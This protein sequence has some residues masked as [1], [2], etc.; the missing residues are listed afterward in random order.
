VNITILSTDP[1]HPINAYLERWIAKN[2]INHKISLVRSPDDLLGGNFLFLVS[3]GSIISRA[4]RQMYEHSLVLH[5]SDLPKGRGWSP[6]IW[7]ICEGNED[8]YLCLLNAEDIV[9]SG[10]IWLKK[11]IHIPKTFLWNEINHAIFE[12]EIHLLDEFLICHDSITP[13]KQSQIIQST[14]YPRR[15]PADSQIDP[16]NSLASQF[17]VMRVSDPLRYPAYFE[18]HGQVYKLILEKYDV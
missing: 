5:A 10:D 1:F 6:H 11:K 16:Y 17:N 8:L 4:Q 3:C 13:I 2:S 9:D 7:S 14:S 12:A 18:M 15:V